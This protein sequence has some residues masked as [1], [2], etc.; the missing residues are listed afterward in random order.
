ME[1]KAHARES[2]VRARELL[3]EPCPTTFLGEQHHEPTSPPRVNFTP[4]DL[5][6]AP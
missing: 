4:L 2:I 6:R 5:A 3:K 1:N